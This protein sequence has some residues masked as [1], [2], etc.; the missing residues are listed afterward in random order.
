MNSSRTSLSYREIP[1]IFVVLIATTY[2]VI[3]GITIKGAV[4]I[5][6]FLLAALLTVVFGEHRKLTLLD[7]LW[8]ISIIPFFYSVKDWSIASF[9]DLAA[10]FAFIVYVVFEKTRR[11]NHRKAIGILLFMAFFNLFFVFVHALFK[12]QF[13]RFLY[14]ILAQGAIFTFERAVKGNYITGLGFIPGDTSGYLVNGILILLFYGRE[15]RS[16]HRFIG[17]AALLAGMLFC[18]KK[19]H[20]ICILLA[21]LIA[22]VFTG[23]GTKKVRRIVIAITGLTA[24]LAV[25][26]FLLPYFSNIPMVNRISLAIEKI[27]A[28]A[29][30]TSNRTNLTKLALKLYEGHEALGI[31]WKSFNQYTLSRWGFTNYV[32]NIYLQLLCETG[33]LGALLFITPMIVTLIR[34][35]SL[36]KKARFRPLDDDY[37]PILSLSLALQLFFL[38]YGFFEIPFYDYTFLFVYALAISLA[39][40]VEIE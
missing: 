20:L 36:M 2:F 1:S 15:M 13:T 38:I 23:R 3:S 40:S 29:D 6:V 21:V 33:V 31:G 30:F 24:L 7:F 35:V 8:I 37:I 34:T 19:S 27:M 26:Y 12:T 18:A 14:S 17:I 22:W 10:Y 11:A 39:N 16:K 5:A 25:G 32:N 4:Q 28:G 9:R